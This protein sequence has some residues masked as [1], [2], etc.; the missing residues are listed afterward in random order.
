VTIFAIAWRL[1]MNSIL[2]F[3][4]IYIMTRP[5]G[6]SIGDFLS[7]S[8]AHGGLGIGATTTTMIFVVGII[9]TVL[10]L[11]ITKK[12]VTQ[13]S[14]LEKEQ[15]EREAHPY[16][17]PQVAAVAIV[18][19][20]VAIGGYYVREMQLHAQQQAIIAANTAASSTGQTSAL[21]DVSQFKTLT[22]TILDSVNAGDWSGANS[23]VNDLEYAWD[24]AEAQLKPIN[25]SAW[26]HVDSAL[27]KVFREVR[28][29]SPDQQKAA[30]ALQSLL[31]T[32]QNP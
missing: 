30:A 7:Q 8:R 14:N 17:L 28:A 13:E 24:H 9:V 18:F 27:D 4:V 22:Q 19:A 6:A 2:A 16:V 1:G 29:V 3:W 23:H 31:S 25:P 10:Y 21:G 32:L 5:L 15:K 11:V 20:I 26:T 12:D